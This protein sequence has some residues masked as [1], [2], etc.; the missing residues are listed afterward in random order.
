MKSVLKGE[1]NKILILILLTLL[2]ILWARVISFEIRQGAFTQNLDTV[3]KRVACAE[4]FGWEVDPGSEKC[5]KIKIPNEFSDVYKNYNSLQKKGGFNLEHYK[6][7][8]VLKYTYIVLNP[9][10]DSGSTFYVNLIIYEGEMIGGDVQ[11]VELN[12][13]MLPIVR[14]RGE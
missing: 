2:F 1:T 10:K 5:E 3:L 12:G 4:W 8:S 7:K 6:G 14:A 11:T 9:P 13:V